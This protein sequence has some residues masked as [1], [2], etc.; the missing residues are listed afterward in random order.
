MAFL[1][2]QGL[3]TLVDQ[4]KL[5][6]TNKLAGKVDVE[7]D[8]GLSTNDY[9]HEDK[10]KLDNLYTKIDDKDYLVSNSYV[11]GDSAAY[12]KTGYCTTK[13][14]S[15]SKE[16]SKTYYITLQSK[17]SWVEQKF[18]I[19]G[20]ISENI[21]K[22]NRVFFTANTNLRAEASMYGKT[23]Y[24]DELVIT[25]IAIYKNA[26]DESY[27]DVVIT[28]KS[29]PDAKTT[30][31]VY[32]DVNDF[33]LT[34]ST[35]APTGTKECEYTLTAEDIMFST[36]PIVYNGKVMSTNDFTDEE[37]EKLASLAS[38]DV[39]N[40]LLTDSP[41]KAL[42][43]AQG[44]ALKA[45]ID[46]YD[47]NGNGIVDDAE[48]LAGYDVSYFA[49]YEQHMNQY[50]QLITHDSRMNATTL[51][52]SIE[53]DGSS[54][55]TRYPMTLTISSHSGWFG[56]YQWNAKL[57]NGAPVSNETLRYGQLPPIE[58]FMYSTSGNVTTYML[59]VASGSTMWG[60]GF[61]GCSPSFKFTDKPDQVLE[62]GTYLNPRYG[63]TCDNIG[64]LP[65]VLT[66]N[67]YGTA[68]PAAGTA[69]RIFF[70]KVS[71]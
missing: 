48:K 68:L 15:L 13:T 5:W 7:T 60:H 36:A 14:Y 27:H 26:A 16:A 33:Q 56:Y 38:I 35:A 61:V 58:S 11:L 69:G 46:T 64:A 44:K 59:K 29:N 67:H 49:T 50:S 55:N 51:C 2:K 22:G 1:N 34:T 24:N 43:A 45:T 39:V 40:D 21:Q 70:K 42:S 20:A 17:T 52:F 31:T 37:R 19:E 12:F 57:D 23:L 18:S 53:G 25:S 6:V 65:S 10:E 32:S 63:V 47:T 8:K 41:T 4:I 28:V 62:T 66:S 30:I 71:S 54:S 9:T 3:T